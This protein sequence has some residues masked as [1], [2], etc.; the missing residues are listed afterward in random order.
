MRRVR[1]ALLSPNFNFILILYTKTAQN[2]VY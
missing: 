2:V 1:I